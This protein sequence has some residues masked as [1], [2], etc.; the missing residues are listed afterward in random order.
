MGRGWL[1]YTKTL[2]WSMARREQVG[3][4]KKGGI[5]KRYGDPN[6][7][8]FKGPRW[9]EGNAYGAGKARIHQLQPQG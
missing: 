6:E 5:M 2:M 8:L 4:S 1:D 3:V 9:S 7:G